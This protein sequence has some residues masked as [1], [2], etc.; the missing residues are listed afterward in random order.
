MDG[1]TYYRNK[2]ELVIFGDFF[3][4]IIGEITEGGYWVCTF[5]TQV[6]G[7]LVERYVEILYIFSRLSRTLTRLLKG[8]GHGILGNSIYF[9]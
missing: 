1:G 7:S 2:K 9:R 3:M 8:L 4:K 5:G 6:L